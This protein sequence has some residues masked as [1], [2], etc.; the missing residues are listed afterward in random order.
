MPP[1]QRKSKRKSAGQGKAKAKAAAGQGKA[2]RKPKT[3]TFKVATYKVLKSVHPDTGMTAKGMNVAESIVQDL[4]KQLTAQASALPGQT[5]S[6]R[7]VTTACKLVLQGELQKHAVA[8][9]TKAVTRFDATPGGKGKKKGKTTVS[10]ASRANLMFPPAKA[11]RLAKEG[12]SGVKRMGIRASV[13]LAA[14]LEYVMAEILDLSGNA[15]RDNKRKRISPR[16][17]KLAIGNDKELSKL[18]RGDIMQGG[19]LPNIHKSLL[20]KKQ[21]A[22]E[23]KRQ[24]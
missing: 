7:C 21:L 11:R 15:A 10:S 13:A 16:C 3:G 20:N 12:A 23:E 2:R 24:K 8:E 5:V 1:K 14:V 6:V 17:I 19:V 4:R 22:A 9:M 18:C